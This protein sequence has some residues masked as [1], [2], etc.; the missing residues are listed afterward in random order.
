[1][2]RRICLAGTAVGLT[3]LTVGIGVATA[4]A[5]PTSKVVLKCTSKL[6]AVPAGGTAVVQQPP[7]GGM[8][9][10]HLQCNRKGHGLGGGVEARTFTV[11]LNGNTNGSYTQFFGSGTLWGTFKLVPAETSFGENFSAESWVGKFTVA[12]GSG[13]FAKMNSV[14]SGVMTCSSADTVHIWCSEKVTLG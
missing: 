6:T 8:E 5:A 7:I 13:A 9:Y 4:T 11:P 2:R 14:A 1:M 10:G 3:A 12:G